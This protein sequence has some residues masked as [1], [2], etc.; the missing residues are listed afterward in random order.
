MKHL[1]I[2]FFILL[3]PLLLLVIS[4]KE[5]SPSLLPAQTERTYWLLLHRKTNVEFLFHG[6]PGDQIQSTLVKTF[7][8]KSGEPQKRPTP[9]PRLMGREYWLIVKKFKTP[10][11]PEIAPFFL[12]L[13]IPY[14][15]K[16]PFGP[17]PYLECNGQCNWELPGSFGLHGI[18]GDS[19]R[20]APENPGSSGCVRHN[21]EDISY[22]YHLLDPEREPIRYYIEDK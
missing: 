11:N 4:A 22:L 14:S 21:D 20:L 13:D 17:A 16:Y 3:L 19:S 12:T 5:R 7:E 8:V 9:L 2:S 18:N 10:D 1:F 15:D 6:T